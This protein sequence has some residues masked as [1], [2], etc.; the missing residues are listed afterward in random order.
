MTSLIDEQTAYSL[1]ADEQKLKILLTELNR[2]ESDLRFKAQDRFKFDTAVPWWVSTLSKTHYAMIII[3]LFLFLILTLI[4]G[5]PS[6]FLKVC[7]TVGLIVVCFFEAFNSK[8][9]QVGTNRINESLSSFNTS[10]KQELLYRATLI[11]NTIYTPSV[12]YKVFIGSFVF[13]ILVGT[14]VCS[15]FIPL[16]VRL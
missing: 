16:F 9:N 4:F 13:S 14:F 6:I 12:F 5:V 15:W 8:K 2:N 7:A 1:M 11:P 3:P 10:R